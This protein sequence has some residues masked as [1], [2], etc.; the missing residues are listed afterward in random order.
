[1]HL[2]SNFILTLSK[3]TTLLFPLIRLETLSISRFL[4]QSMNTI[5]LLGKRKREPDSQLSMPESKRHKDERFNSLLEVAVQLG[6]CKRGDE[7]LQISLPKGTTVAETSL[8]KAKCLKETSECQSGDHLS[9]RSPSN[10]HHGLRGFYKFFPS[11][12]TLALTGTRS[13]ISSIKLGASSPSFQPQPPI[14]DS[15][16]TL[17]HPQTLETDTHSFTKSIHSR[18]FQISTQFSPLLPAGVGSAYGFVLPGTSSSNQRSSSTHLIEEINLDS[19]TPLVDDTEKQ[20]FVSSLKDACTSVCI[21]GCNHRNSDNKEHQKEE[22]RSEGCCNSNDV[23][24]V[25]DK[26]HKD[27]A[28]LV[29]P[30]VLSPHD[31]P[32]GI[33]ISY[34]HSMTDKILDEHTQPDTE[35][36]AT[37]QPSHHDYVDSAS[38]DTVFSIPQEVH[39]D[40]AHFDFHASTID[41]QLS[42]I[43]YDIDTYFNEGDSHTAYPSDTRY[44]SVGETIPSTPPPEVHSQIAH[45][46]FN[47]NVRLSQFFEE[48]KP[49]VVEFGAIGQPPDNYFHPP[50]ERYDDLQQNGDSQTNIEYDIVDDG[51][52]DFFDPTSVTTPPSDPEF[53]PGVAH[54]DFDAATVGRTFEDHT[55]IGVKLRLIGQPFNTNVAAAVDAYDYWQQN[56]EPQTNSE[57]DCPNDPS[58][59]T[60]ISTPPP[61]VQPDGGHHFDPEIGSIGQSPDTKVPAIVIGFNDSK[62]KSDSQTNGKYHSS[63]ALFSTPPPD[64]TDNHTHFDIENGEIGHGSATGVPTIVEGYNDSQQSSDPPTNSEYYLTNDISPDA[65]LSTPT[66]NAQLDTDRFGLDASG[67]Q[68]SNSTHVDIENCADKGYLPCSVPCLTHPMSLQEPVFGSHADGNPTVPPLATPISLCAYNSL[69]LS[70]AYLLSGMEPTSGHGNEIARPFPQTHLYQHEFYSMDVDDGSIV[71]GCDDSQQSYDPPTSGEYDFTNDIFSTP[72][73]DVRL[74]PGQFELNAGGGQFSNKHTH[75]GVEVCQDEGHSEVYPQPDME[76]TNEIGRERIRPLLQ[77]RPSHEHDPYLMDIDDDHNLEKLRIWMIAEIEG[78]IQDHVPE[79]MK[80][81]FRKFLSLS[82]DEPSQVMIAL[83]SYV[84]AAQ[85]S[86]VPTSCQGQDGNGNGGAGD[87]AVPEHRNVPKKCPTDKIKLAARVREEIKKILQPHGKKL[88]DRCAQRWELKDYQEA[89]IAGPTVENFKLDL[90]SKGVVAAGEDSSASSKRVSK[91]Q[92]DWRTARR[93]KLYQCRMKAFEIIRLRYPDE[94]LE[95]LQEAVN[96]ITWDMMSGDET[97]P[98]SIDCEEKRY[99]IRCHEWVSTELS[100]FLEYLSALYIAFQYLENGAYSQGVFPLIRTCRPNFVE[101]NVHTVPKECPQNFYSQAWLRDSPDHAMTIQPSQDLSL[102]L[103]EAATQ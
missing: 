47:L 38:P 15:S 98:Q 78:I 44:D 42:Q 95:Q 94:V 43:A 102:K 33:D 39:P 79:Q 36:G 57:Y 93:E 97:D 10:F 28:L 70:K 80:A 55:D 87:D 60:V 103:P 29:Q 49:I 58:P 71:D 18:P 84:G 101:G 92:R 35:C 27:S 19:R 96:K 30:M 25:D 8:L 22:H 82:A 1:M 83:H 53:H 3:P 2:Y 5:T 88:S 64:L 11:T 100:N 73:P 14:S 48:S 66:Q 72:P 81:H 99:W 41:H 89:K 91:K 59:G 24:R 63:Q 46:D 45:S 32:G 7:P 90:E 34:G 16:A 17:A 74:N 76:F 37:A 9:L 68:F 54:P 23:A 51:L 56:I 65:V 4:Q 52:Y 6:K 62:Q 75:V 50:V 40:I 12:T 20:Y 67:A 69:A 86:T 26:D 61:N 21:V 85:H 31:T 77:T 13:G